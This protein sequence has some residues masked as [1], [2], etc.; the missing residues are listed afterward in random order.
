[1]EW[2]LHVGS[3]AYGAHRARRGTAPR[4][5]GRASRGIQTARIDTV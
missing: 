2:T 5:C 3:K 1:M 4:R